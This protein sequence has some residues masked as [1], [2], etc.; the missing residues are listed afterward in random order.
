MYF[1]GSY[2]KTGSGTCVFLVSPQGHKLHYTTRLHFNATNNVAEY[3]ALINGLYIVAEVG[4][5]GSWSRVTP[6]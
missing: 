2:L 4:A 6:S 1:D 3:E 5:R